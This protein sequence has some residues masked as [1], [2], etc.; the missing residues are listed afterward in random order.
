MRSAKKVDASVLAT[1]STREMHRVIDRQWGNETPAGRCALAIM[2]KAPRA[3]T[4]KTR[5]QPPLTPSDAAEL[6]TCVLR[7]IA[8]LISAAG[9]RSQGVAVFTAARSEI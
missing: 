2:T 3:G 8:A 5:L 7:D 6:N 9:E 4:G 1:Q